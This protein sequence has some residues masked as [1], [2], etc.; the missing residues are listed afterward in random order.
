MIISR[1][2]E[3]GLRI[4]DDL[5]SDYSNFTTHFLFGRWYCYGR[6]EMI[7]YMTQVLLNDFAERTVFHLSMR[8]PIRVW[9]ASMESAANE[10]LLSSIMKNYLEDLEREDSEIR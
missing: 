3:N 10:E 9:A 1:T 8:N 6:L 2:S 7:K 4:I 5:I